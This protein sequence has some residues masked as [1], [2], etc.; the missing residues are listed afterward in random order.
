MTASAKAASATQST[1]DGT[2][3]TATTTA[4]MITAT[5]IDDRSGQIPPM[6]PHVDSDDF[7]LVE[8][9][10][11]VRHRLHGRRRPNSFRRS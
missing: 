2:E 3:S 10:V 11:R 7:A 4:A 9:V 8:H 6:G 5:R 1:H